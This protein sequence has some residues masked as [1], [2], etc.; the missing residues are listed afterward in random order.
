MEESPAGKRYNEEKTKGRKWDMERF[1]LLVAGGGFAGTAA[2]IAAARQGARVLLIEKINCLGGAACSSLVNPFMPFWTSLPG[3]E[4]ARSLCNGIFAEV[5]AGLRE[6][7]ALGENGMTFDEEAFKLLLNRMALKAGV[8]LLFHAQIAQVQAENGVIRSVL[9]AT[10]GGPVT[11]EA[12][13]FIDATGDGTLSML[14]GCQFHLGR[15]G[16]HLCQPMTL[17]FRMD[18]VDKEKFQQ[19]RARI[20]PLYR[21]FQ[22]EGKIKNIREDVLIFDTLHDGILHFNSTRIVRRNPTDSFDL[23]LAEI[24]ARE[25]VYELWHF[26]RD[27]IPGFENSRVLSTAIQIGTRE[28]RMIDGEYCLTQEDLKN[29]VHFPDGIAAG[30]YDIDIHNPEGSGTSHYFFA[31]G[32]WYTIP[33]RCLLPVGTKNLLV[34]GRCISSTH[35]AQASYRIMPIV[36]CIGEAAGTAAGVACRAHTSLRGVDVEQVRAILKAGGAPI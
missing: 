30:N 19:N 17:C 25:Q 7:N 13:T 35:E 15:E 18:Q 14:A 10:P 26:L 20:N 2:A 28:S 3:E 1:D 27:N 33:Y 21:Q 16:D 24:E 31:P 22:Q 6:M 8:R 5:L 4:K 34:A 36:C 29:C 32:T 9:C 11:L 12:E 23:T